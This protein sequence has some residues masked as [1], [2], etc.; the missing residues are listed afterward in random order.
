MPVMDGVQ[1]VEWMKQM[2]VTIPILVLTLLDEEPLI[3][4]LFR[5]GIRGYLNKNCNYE[6]LRN[7]LE[8]I[9]TTGYYHD[10]MMHKALTFDQEQIQQEPEKQ[11][12]KMM[13]NENQMQFLRLVCHEDEYTY[14]QISSIMNVTKKTVE[15]YRS[16]LFEMLGIKSKIGLVLFAIKNNLLD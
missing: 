16:Q 2:K 11:S 6:Q 1:V 13:L 15:H 9:F 14:D 7:A 3:I 8:Q 10:E 5:K 4:S 12:V